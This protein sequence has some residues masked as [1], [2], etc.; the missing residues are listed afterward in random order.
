MDI[1]I[2]TVKKISKLANLEITPEEQQSYTEELKA[3]INWINSLQKVDTSS[4]DE[5]WNNDSTPLRQD[6]ITSFNIQQDVLSNTAS[7]H[8]CFVTPKV[9]E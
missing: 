2:N 9:I 8:G 5:N 3:V 6:K 7:K 1:D 4:T